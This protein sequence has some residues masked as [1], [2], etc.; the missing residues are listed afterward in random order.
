MIVYPSVS[1]SGNGNSVPILIPSSGIR[2]SEFRLS[3][4]II[5]SLGLICTVS[6]GATLTYAVQISNDPPTQA[7]TNWNAHDTL[8]ALNA[9]ANG[10]IAFPVTA[11]R[12]TVSGWSSGSVNLGVSQWP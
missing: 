12:L 9:S 7:I 8:T 4:S 3:S 10:N 1:L 6:S 5:V 2:L 11:I